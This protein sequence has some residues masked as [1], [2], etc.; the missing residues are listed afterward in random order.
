[1][2]FGFGLR[3]ARRYQV[4]SKNSYIVCVHMLDNALIE[5]TLTADSTGQDCL[6]NIAAR[7]NLIEFQY[8]GLRYENNKLQFRWVEMDKPL[9]KQLD[10]NA[11]SPLLYFGVMFYVS[12][13]FTIQ[14]DVS[15]SVVEF[16]L[17]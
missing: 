17:L 4:S 14:D 15:R 8:F 13:V 5:C 9:K 12:D 7:I 10:K 2:P 11:H 3:K 16:F 6:E 1:M